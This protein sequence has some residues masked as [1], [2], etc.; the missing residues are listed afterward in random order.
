MKFDWQHVA[1]LGIGLACMTVVIALGKGQLLLQ[2]VA[3]LGG[4]SGVA[5]LLKQPPRS[6]GDS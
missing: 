3:A 2:L 1:I 4:L 6:G 5:A